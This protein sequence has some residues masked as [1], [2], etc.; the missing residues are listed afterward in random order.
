VCS[1]TRKSDGTISVV[2]ESPEGQFRNVQ[3]IQTERGARTLAADRLL[4]KLFTA[5]ADFRPDVSQ[6]GQEPHRPE[7]IP[8]TFRVLIVRSTRVH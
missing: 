8:G 1:G 2:S 4:H 6:I 5:T 7:A 3:T